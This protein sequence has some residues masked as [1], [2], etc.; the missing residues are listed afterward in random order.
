MDKPIFV[1]LRKYY[2]LCGGYVSPFS[3]DGGDILL[4]DSYDDAKAFALKWCGR[5]A[6]RVSVLCDCGELSAA[7]C[8]CDNLVMQCRG[9]ECFD[10]TYVRVIAE[11]YQKYV[12]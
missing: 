9:N 6:P 1:V 3:P 12:L 4:F 11:V 2:H 7:A 8:K 10:N 5:L